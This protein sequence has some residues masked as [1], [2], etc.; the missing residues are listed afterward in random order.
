MQEYYKCLKGTSDLFVEYHFFLELLSKLNFMIF[1]EKISIQ[2][3]QNLH[4]Q[5][6][7]KLRKNIFA[8]TTE[9]NEI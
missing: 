1:Q 2:A 7:Q 3:L 5:N 9:M 4:G 8:F 6:V